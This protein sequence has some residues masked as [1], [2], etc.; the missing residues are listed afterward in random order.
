METLVGSGLWLMFCA[1][2]NIH[3]QPAITEMKDMIEAIQDHLVMRYHD[4]RRVLLH[5]D[6]SQQ[7]A[8][9]LIEIADPDCP[10]QDEVELIS[11]STAADLAIFP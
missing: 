7:E 6:P 9:G 4:N 2:R 11:L 5:C 1:V 10:Q 8:A 3:L